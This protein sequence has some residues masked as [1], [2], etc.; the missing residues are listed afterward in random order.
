MPE[1][2]K[3]FFSFGDRKGDIAFIAE[4]NSVPAGSVWYR[5]WGSKDNM[6]G[7]VHD[8]VPVLVIAVREEFRRKGIGRKLLLKILSELKGEVSLCVSKDNPVLV[9]YKKEGF[10]E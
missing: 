7:F 5:Y 6:R 1:V 4:F 8:E 9:L 2:A 10:I 3:A